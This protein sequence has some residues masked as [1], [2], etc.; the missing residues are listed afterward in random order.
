[1]QK[2]KEK[3]KVATT[4]MKDKN[5]R[6]L[7]QQPMSPLRVSKSPETNSQVLVI[8][9]C[10]LISKDY[11]ICI[12]SIVAFIDPENLSIRENLNRENYVNFQNWAK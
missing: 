5:I 7:P 11:S 8:P 9:A 12:L 3:G 4:R 1:M 10:P 2:N 6:M